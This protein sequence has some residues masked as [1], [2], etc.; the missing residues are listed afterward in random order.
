MTIIAW[1]GGDCPVHPKTVVSVWL[2]VGEADTNIASLFE[3]DQRTRLWN[4]AYD[5]IAYEVVKEY[6]EP[7]EI[8]VNEYTLSHFAY[9]DKEDAL[10]SGGPE[11]IRKAVH[12]REVVEE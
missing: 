10:N 6:K 9:D 12:Y 7:K 5:I 2:R 4:E 8:W 11:V 1:N 3:W